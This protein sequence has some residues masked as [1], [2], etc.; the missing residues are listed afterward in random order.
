MHIPG[1]PYLVDQQY[2]KVPAQELEAL[3]IDFLKQCLEISK[4][5]EAVALRIN[6]D[7]W[8][9]KRL[10]LSSFD[11][12]LTFFQSSNATQSI[13]L[14]VKSLGRLMFPA[15]A[16]VDI[17]DLKTPS[18]N[19]PSQQSLQQFIEDNKDFW[20]S[21]SETTRKQ[22]RRSLKGDFRITTEVNQDS[23]QAAY[24]LMENTAER[25]GFK[26]PS[27]DYFVTMSTE[28]FFHL[29][30]IQDM[31]GETHTAWIGIQHG[32]TLTN[33]YAGNDDFG[34]KNFFPNLSHV[35][36]MYLAK[37]LGCTTY[38][39]GGYDSESGPMRFK[40]GYKP[41][42]LNFV[43]GVDL[44]YLPWYYR[45]IELGGKGKKILRK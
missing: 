10:G 1:G 12:L 9:A 23:L 26:V 28:P 41:E 17:S 31:K 27:Y 3:L 7:P 22:S 2:D 20:L 4:T 44:V 8:Y 24:R 33:Q 40:D 13:G 29:A 37:T 34:F 38:D 16:T 32:E 45:I 42:I 21:K 35:Y 39:L 18:D 19:H 30:L 43:G 6:L 36:G 25:Q 14:P 15:I 11:D 5:R